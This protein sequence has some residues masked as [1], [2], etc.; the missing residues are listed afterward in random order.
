MG[1]LA[2]REGGEQEAGKEEEA[3]R[4]VEGAARQ[5]S[6]KQWRMHEMKLRNLRKI[7]TNCIFLAVSSEIIDQQLIY[8]IIA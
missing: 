8:R 3:V 7:G 2:V 5:G 4:Q 1:R 6:G